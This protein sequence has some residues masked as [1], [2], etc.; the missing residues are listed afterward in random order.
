MAIEAEIA[1][2]TDIVRLKAIQQQV[3]ARL[4]NLAVGTF[5]AKSFVLINIQKRGMGSHIAYIQKAPGGRCSTFHII[6]LS[7]N[8]SFAERRWRV[9]PQSL[10]PLPENRKEEAK[11]LLEGL[12]KSDP[13]LMIDR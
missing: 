10:L 4:E 3:N 12:K 6:L 13:F 5:G 9:H 7:E 1:S 11:K 8:L 2:M